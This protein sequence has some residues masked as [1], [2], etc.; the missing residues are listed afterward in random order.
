M[1]RDIVI[2]EEYG[3]TAQ[4]GLFEWAVEFLRDSVTDPETK[5]WLRTVLDENLGMVDLK[6]LPD[7]GRREILRA[8][9]EDFVPAIHARF[10]DDPQSRGHLK[11][12]TLMARDT[13]DPG[14]P[15]DPDRRG[16]QLPTRPD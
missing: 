15:P 9:R 11:V 1:G 10:P 3:W 16:G 6:S 8:L 13:P 4:F 5:S 14:E 12:L 2:T 7:T